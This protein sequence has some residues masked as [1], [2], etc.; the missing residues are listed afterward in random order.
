M[1]KKV[2]VVDDHTLIANAIGNMVN[3]FYNYNVLFEAENGKVFIE[4]LAHSKSVPDVVL[5]DISM[6]VMD[7]FETA[8]W[9]RDNLPKTKIMA[10]STMDDE[11]SLMKMIRSGAT[12]YL[13]KN[14]QPGELHKALDILLEKGV[15][16]PE[17]AL[18]KINHSLNEP[19]AA[20]K[21]I[22]EVVKFTEKEELFIK[23]CCTEMTYKEMAEHMNI[24][25]RTV[26]NYR[27][28]VFSKLYVNNR[29]GVVIFA[30]K[31]GRFGV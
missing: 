19:D 18:P 31:T 28:M 11:D 15:Y 1:S 20:K 21:A 4:K 27:D 14:I 7:G 29:I 24:G 25:V 23:L 12:G 16:Y 10:L 5:L 26:D 30:I 2:V 3:G 9:I 17:W 8:A 6:P 13:L 22:K